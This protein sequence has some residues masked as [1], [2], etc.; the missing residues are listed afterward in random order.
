MEKIKTYVN[1]LSEPKIFKKI[2]YGFGALFIASLIFQA[3]MFVGFHKASYRHDMDGNFSK[4]FG[5]RRGGKMM[6][7]GSP[8]NFPNAHGSIGKV[9]KVEFPTM[10]VADKDNTE[11]V[12]LITDDT[13]FRKMR[14]DGTKDDIN[15]D[16]YVVVIGSPNTE[17]QIEAKLIRILPAPSPEM[18]REKNSDNR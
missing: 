17:G 1:K 12:I 3:G 15:V 13:Q 14:E 9:I 16:S 6:M 4:N 7:K 11:K 5:P 18:M 2:M 10:I 8:E